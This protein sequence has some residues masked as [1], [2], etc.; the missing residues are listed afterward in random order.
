MLVSDVYRG[1]HMQGVRRG[2][3][4]VSWAG[5]ETKRILRTVP[6]MADGSAYFRVPAERFVYFQL[7]D[8]DGMLIATRRSGA[9]VQPGEAVGCVGC[10]EDRLQAPPPQKSVLAAHRPPAE[11]T[12]WYGPPRAFSYRREIQPIWDRHCVKCHDLGRKA[13]EKLILA[14]DR[15]LV[16]NASYVEL[17]QRWGR[18]E[19]LLNTVGLGLAPLNAPRAADSPRS[20]L[21]QLLRKGHSDVKL[22][23]E[24]MDRIV[25]WIDI[26]GPYY[27]DHACAHPD[28]VAGRAPISIPQARRLGE[29]TGIG[30][31][32]EDGNPRY[33][34]HRFRISFDRPERSPCLRD[35]DPNS[36]AYTEALGII[37]AGR[38]ELR[39]NPGADMPGFV[40]CSEHRSREEKY[41]RLLGR[42]RRSRQA[43][44]KGERLY[45]PAI[46]PEQ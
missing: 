13:G 46:N 28:N 40:A 17:F 24:E 14:G 5:F 37:R 33:W 26:G 1:T 11:L 19:A 44:A 39:E 45:E 22:S 32:E 21:V 23:P 12:G 7:L 6:V 38:Q 31:V 8:R 9:L 20:R 34:Q 42:E 10:H 3:V 2:E 30:L 4:A 16:F 25:T 15:E 41:Q 27:P 18:Q 35:L 43:I 36:A 29:F